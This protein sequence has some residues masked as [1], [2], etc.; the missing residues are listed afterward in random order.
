MTYGWIPEWPKGTDCKSAATR[1]GGSNPPCLLY[2]SQ[3][4]EMLSFEEDVRYRTIVGM[5]E[6]SGWG[7]LFP[8]IVLR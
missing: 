1:F 4:W 3:R 8:G 2:T 5:Q 6:W 7:K